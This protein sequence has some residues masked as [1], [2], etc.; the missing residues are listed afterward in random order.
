[1]I[2]AVI[3]AEGRAAGKVLHSRAR[4]PFLV[5]VVPLIDVLHP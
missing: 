3:M 1:M 5:H 2:T 4:L